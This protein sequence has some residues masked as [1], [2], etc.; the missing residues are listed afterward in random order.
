MVFFPP[1]KKKQKNKKQKQNKKKQNKK[2]EKYNF[3][4]TIS[5]L[6]DQT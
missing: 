1:P 5:F 4:A 2:S 6:S 3:D